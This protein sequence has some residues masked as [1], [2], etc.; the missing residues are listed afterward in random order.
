M[1]VTGAFHPRSTT[2]EVLKAQH[3]QSPSHASLPPH[4]SARVADIIS[5]VLNVD[6]RQAR[7]KIP[8][9]IRCDPRAGQPDKLQ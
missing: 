2:P 3:R 7:P 8:E 6:P 1:R 9:A 5:S 4:G